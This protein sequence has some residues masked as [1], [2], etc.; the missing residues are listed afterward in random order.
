MPQ[1]SM[2]PI[3]VDRLRAAQELDGRSWPD[4]ARALDTQ[5]QR[6]YHL[7]TGPGRAQRGAARP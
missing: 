6:L 1:S 4:I 7:S 5:H 3:R 2:V